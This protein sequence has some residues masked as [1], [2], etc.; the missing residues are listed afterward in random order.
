[1][2]FSRAVEKPAIMKEFQTGISGKIIVFDGEYRGSEFDIYFA[3]NPTLEQ[4]SYSLVDPVTSMELN[5]TQI[6]PLQDTAP[7]ERL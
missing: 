1:M 3:I 2:E 6:P 5:S 4:L 7:L